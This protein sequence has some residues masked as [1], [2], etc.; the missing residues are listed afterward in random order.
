MQTESAC[1]DNLSMRLGGGRRKEAQG[2][3]K[4]GNERA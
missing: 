3:E 4:N 2:K 1:V